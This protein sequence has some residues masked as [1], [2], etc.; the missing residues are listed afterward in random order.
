[1]KE[2]LAAI[3]NGWVRII[4]FL[5]AYIVSVIVL[6]T[7]L[8]TLIITRKVN[9]EMNS[10]TVLQL[11]VITSLIS[12][13]LVVVFRI[14]IDKKSVKSLGLLPF[15]KDALLGFLLSIVI[16]GC[17]TLLL[18]A[19][20]NLQWTDFSFDA[21]PFFAGLGILLLVAFAE[22]MVFRGYILNNLLAVS[23]NKWA[24]LAIS[25]LLFTAV[26]MSNLG[27]NVVAV[28]NLFLAGCLL[29]LNYIY[30][31]NLWFAILFHF[32]WN[33]FQGPVLGF[34]VSGLGMSA[35]LQ[36]ELSGNPLL[37]GDKF[38]FEGS[39][40][41]TMLMLVTILLL[42]LAFEKRKPEE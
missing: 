24:A 9:I 5:L 42:Y 7:V 2:P 31:K 1:M 8:A 12:L 21:G 23:N 25:S 30:T 37:T 28:L 40:I 11:L 29:G 41:A 20:G 26:H 18:Y 6:S 16:L 38:G 3:P 36:P 15:T 19:N 32:G 33:F 35:I 39:L 22:E 10:N 27:I 4:L 17:G 13:L 14:Y 34:D